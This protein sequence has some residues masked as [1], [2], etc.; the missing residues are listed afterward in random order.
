MKKI[1]LSA[2]IIASLTS[3]KKD[4]TCECK[5]T[6]TYPG[7][8]GSTGKSNTGKMKKQ[9]AIEKCNEGDKTINSVYFDVQSNQLKEYT[10]TSS[11]ELI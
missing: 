2:I 3:C 11:C 7:I 5:S 1:F 10:I 4:Y 9:H 6:S 8:P